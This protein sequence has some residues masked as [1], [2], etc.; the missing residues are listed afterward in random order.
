[1]KQ[2]VAKFMIQWQ[3]R[4]ILS[5]YMIKWLRAIYADEIENHETVQIERERV[6]N[7]NFFINIFI[8]TATSPL[9]SLKS[10]LK[11]R[12]SSRLCF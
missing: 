7:Y 10:K 2:K 3:S 1:M 6:F 12:N 11:K 5:T 9:D 8:E 4:K